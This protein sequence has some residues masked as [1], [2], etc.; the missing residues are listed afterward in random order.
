MMMVIF[1]VCDFIN[2]IKDTKCSVNLPQLRLKKKKE[3]K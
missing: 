3:N 2:E 1:N